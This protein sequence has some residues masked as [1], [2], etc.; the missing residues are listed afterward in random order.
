LSQKVSSLKSNVETLS[1]PAAKKA[2]IK[3]K[4]A[5]LQVLYVE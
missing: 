4:I 1:I 5:V 2:E 3:A